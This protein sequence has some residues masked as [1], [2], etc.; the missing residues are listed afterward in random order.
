[1]IKFA[2]IHANA[3]LHSTARFAYLSLKIAKVKI[4]LF[5]ELRKKNCFDNFIRHWHIS[6][7]SCTG[8]VLA[9]QL[10]TFSLLETV[11]ECDTVI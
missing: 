1:M 5:L 3:Q 4:D 10:E 11:K 8:L 6:T 7:F 2:D 9:I